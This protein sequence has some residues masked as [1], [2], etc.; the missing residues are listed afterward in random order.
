MTGTNCDLF[1]HKSSRSY[2]NHLVC[3]N[4]WLILIELCFTGIILSVQE[5]KLAQV[6]KNF[7]TVII[8][9]S[10]LFPLCLLAVYSV[11]SHRQHN[12]LQ[13]MPL[14]VNSCV[15]DGLIK[16]KLWY[17]H[18]L[19][20]LIHCCGIFCKSGYYIFCSIK[21]IRLRFRRSE[22]PFCEDLNV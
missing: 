17:F 10:C 9:L 12:Y 7:F 4:L 11:L 21:F 13:S 3:R 18:I 19:S 22:S 6:M 5:V 8:S 20:Q 16:C 1:T 2:L 14:I 15:D